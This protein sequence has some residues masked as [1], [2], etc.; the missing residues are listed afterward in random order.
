MAKDMHKAAAQ[1]HEHAAKAH[2]AAAEHHEKGAIVYL[3]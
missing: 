3:T 1:H 2:H